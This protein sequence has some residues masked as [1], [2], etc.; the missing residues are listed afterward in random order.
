MR[1]AVLAA[2]REGAT[3]L[4]P[5]PAEFFKVNERDRA[6]VDAQCTA[7]PIKCF[8]QKLTLTGARERIAKKTYIRA[9]VY[10]SQY[11][12]TGLASARAKNWRIHEVECGH[13]VMLDMPERLA[14]ILQEAR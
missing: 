7:Q 11:F 3:R 8:L 4:P 1:D 6:W 13:D 2:E 9:T 12:D 5:R 10:P 14:E